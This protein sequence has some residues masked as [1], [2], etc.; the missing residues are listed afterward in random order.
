[1]AFCKRILKKGLDSKG[2]VKTKE[3]FT[4]NSHVGFVGAIK[5]GMPIIIHNVHGTH[6]ATPA[7]KML[8]KD[9]EDMILW[10][11]TDNDVLS[12][13]KNTKENDGSV[14]KRDKK[15]Y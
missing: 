13:I 6:M 14:I 8:S 15:W 9:S 3:P 10:V 4:F 2:N 12:V 5:D 1:M 7:N 11:V